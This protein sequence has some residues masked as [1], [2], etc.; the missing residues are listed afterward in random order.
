MKRPKLIR[1]FTEFNL[2]R[3]N[4]DAVQPA[5]WVQNPELSI[6]AFD[7]HQDMIRQALS[8]IGDIHKSLGGSAAYKN[9]KSRLSLDDQNVQSLKIIRITRNANFTYD[10]YISF[11]IDEEEYWG[12]IK[13]IL[14]NAQVISEVFTDTSLIQ[15]HI[16]VK[17]LKGFLIKTI[18]TFLK[19]QTGK[20]KLLRDHV[21]CYSSLDGKMMKIKQGAEVEVLKSYND[22][23]HISYEGDQYVLRNE[24]FIYF[25]WWFEK[26]DQN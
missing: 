13:D 7:K 22:R 4:P 12:V 6:D 21:I 10:V 25:N 9:L 23:I 2:Q 24:N 26:L 16:W 3:F 17:R 11:N 8:R 18:Q 14:G 20:F 19:P 1:E 15:T 5:M